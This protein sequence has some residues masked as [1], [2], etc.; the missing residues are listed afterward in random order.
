MTLPI[1]TG[2]GVLTRNGA[3]SPEG[4]QFF[5]NVIGQGIRTF[6]PSAS[7][8]FARE[9]QALLNGRE[10]AAGFRLYDVGVLLSKDLTCAIERTADGDLR[11]TLTTGRCGVV[12]SS[13]QPTVAGKW[14]DPRVSLTFG[15]SMSFT[16]HIP[17]TT[18]EGLRLS[19]LQ[20]LRILA[21]D[22][23]SRSII[24]DLAF[25]LDD[26]LAFFRGVRIVEELQNQL[27][28]TDFAKT[29]N[30]SFLDKA[31]VPV[32]AALRTLS[33][34]GFWYL[35]ALVDVL[36]GSRSLL[37]G[38]PMRV[39]GAPANTMSLA[40]VARGLDRSGVVEGTITWPRALGGPKPTLRTL[41]SRIGE[42]RLAV[43]A[44]DALR[45]AE[46]VFHPLPAVQVPVD[47]A[48]AYTAMPDIARRSDGTPEASREEIASTD[49][50]SLVR[51]VR[52]LATNE[53]QIALTGALGGS[54]P[55][56]TG[57]VGLDPVVR[58][59][60]ALRRGVDDLVVQAH[61]T[62][63]GPSGGFGMNVPVGELDGLWADDDETTCRRS[64]RLTGVPVD[65]PLLVTVDLG[66]G[67][68]WSE[69]TLAGVPDGW[70]SAPV[71]HTGTDEKHRERPVRAH[72]TSAV[73]R[74]IGRGV[75]V[76]LNPQ[77]LPPKDLPW[78]RDVPGVRGTRGPLSQ[79]V[80]SGGVRD[81][82]A[83]D[84]GVLKKVRSVKGVA[85]DLT[86][87]AGTR[88]RTFD[89]VV[90]KNR[91]EEQIVIDPKKIGGLFGALRDETSILRD[92]DMKLIV[93]TVPIVR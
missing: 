28:R 29:V 81:A 24:T 9:L 45:V 78:R 35:D 10:V 38:T 34:Q 25:F 54:V 8:T 15:L 63:P 7:A 67:Y 57:L 60:T 14:A 26:V 49:E 84:A 12:V 89:E 40:L 69:K 47:Q 39:P 20:T 17:S 65:T 37:G 11:L 55:A 58:E 52:E 82:G 5:E 87:E 50:P 27:A 70:S 59:A 64:Y 48:T 61:A 74:Q 22:I 72:V 56:L 2:F 66:R 1:G 90:I 43:D 86:T 71:V 68:R 75:E 36:D 6:W 19:P 53:R 46:P 33:D 30:G 77:P 51:G 16:L 32:N 41:V 44:L 18:A 42:A 92:V 93:E 4:V 13:T 21:P 3:D 76:A 91:R 88:V 83:I 85:T 79:E 31:L 23:D 80:N 73:V 62:K